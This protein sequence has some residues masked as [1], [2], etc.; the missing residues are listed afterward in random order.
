MT[1]FEDFFKSIQGIV[2]SYTK[3]GTMLKVSSDLESGI[4]KVFGEGITSLSRA[5]D[6]LD[7]VSELAYT[8]A[9][10]HPYWNLLYCS[11]QISKILLEKWNENLTG[12]EMDELL[13]LIGEMKNAH[14]KMQS[15]THSCQ[16]EINS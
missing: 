15:G 7:D 14:E 4:I 2:D 3:Q 6:G 1:Q 8:T 16:S 10:H 13:W 11:S 5:K 9:E 12:E